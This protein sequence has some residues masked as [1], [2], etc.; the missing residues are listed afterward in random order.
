MKIEAR[1]FSSKWMLAGIFILGLFIRIHGI[2]TESLSFDEI[3]SLKLA[4]MTLPEIIN[5]TSKDY[6]PPLYYA[7]LHFWVILFG[8]TEISIRL[9][10]ALLGAA[11]VPA[12]FLLGR[13]IFSERAGLYAAFF[14]AASNINI[15]HSQEARMYTL[16]LLLA[17]LSFYFLHQILRNGGLRSYIFFILC[18]AAMIYTHF[19]GF[20]VAAAGILLLILIAVSGR[21]TERRSLMKPAGAVI[22]SLLMYLPWLPVF[23]KQY[24]TAHSFLWI[25]PATLWQLPEAVTEFA[26]SGLLLIILLPLSVLVFLQPVMKNRRQSPSE[27]PGI[28]LALKKQEPAGSI[29]LLLW[30]IIPVLIPFLI[31]ILM[32]PIF[33]VKYT[34]ASSSAFLLL[35]AGG[36]AEVKWKWGRISIIVVIAALSF[37]NILQ[38]HALPRGERWKEAAAYIDANAGSSD[39]IVFNSAECRDLYKY[40][41]LRKDLASAGYNPGWQSQ[42]ADSIAKNITPFIENHSTVYLVLS[43]SRYQDKVLKAFESLSEKK[44]SLF[45][46]SYQRRYFFL[47]YYNSSS[48]D[49]YLKK[50][51]LSPEIMLYKFTKKTADGK[52]ANDNVTPSRGGHASGVQVK[53]GIFV[54]QSCHPRWGFW[55][56][57]ESWFL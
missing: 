9:L 37:Y 13:L 39:I 17:I 18:N 36:L 21:N 26:G 57:F 14:S 54:L 15:V 47:S 7:L 12:I 56:F 16:L 22:L 40:Y 23:L 53:L 31:S 42:S 34:I 43:H 41:S 29:L 55:M 49:I 4:G 35:C 6:H 8:T 48:Y 1:N 25:P 28:L 38:L 27:Q 52:L 10:S 3:Y 5:E 30:L 51:Y 44:D 19:Y 45:F 2:N 50:A 33:L 46:Y 32:Q 20:F 11:A 24:R